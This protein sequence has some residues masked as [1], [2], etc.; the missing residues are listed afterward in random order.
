MKSVTRKGSHS[1]KIREGLAVKT[2]ECVTAKANFNCSFLPQ[3]PYKEEQDVTALQDRTNK[4]VISGVQS[5]LSDVFK[6]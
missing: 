1:R 4:P 3:K 5:K 2:K 6:Q